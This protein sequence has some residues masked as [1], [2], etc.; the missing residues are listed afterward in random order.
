MTSCTGFPVDFSALS[1]LKC[2]HQFQSRMLFLW[3]LFVYL[4]NTLS[5]DYA[6]VDGAKQLCVKNYTVTVLGPSTCTFHI[7]REVATM[8]LLLLKS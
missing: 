6:S 3:L 1:F 2:R 7:T 8:S 4:L 5:S